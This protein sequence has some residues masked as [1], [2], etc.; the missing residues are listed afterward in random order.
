MVIVLVHETHNSQFDK[1]GKPYAD[2][3]TI[4]TGLLHDVVEDTH[5]SIE[6]LRRMGYSQE[7]LDTLMLLT[8]DK[9]TDYMEY[10]EKVKTNSIAKAVKMADLLYNSDRSRL[11]VISK[12]DEQRFAKYESAMILLKQNDAQ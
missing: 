9:S 10:V 1:G 4:T 2:H 7:V 5:Y 3:N 12:K 6:D 11:E 8:H